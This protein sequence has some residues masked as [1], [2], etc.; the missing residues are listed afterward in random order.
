MSVCNYLAPQEIRGKR[1]AG[2]PTNDLFSLGVIL[3]ECLTGELPW[4]ARHAGELV[5]GAAGGPAPRVSA[6]VLECPVWLDVL[7]ARLLEVK[8][9]GRLPT[10]DATRRAI[11]DAKSKVAAGMG[12]V[13]HALSGQQGRWPPAST[14]RSSSRL[15]KAAMAAAAE[16]H[17]SVLR[18]GVVPGG[19]PGGGDRRRRVGDVAEERG[20]AVR[21][22]E[23]AD[24]FG[25]RDRLAAGAG[26]YLDGVAA[27][28]FPTRRIGDEIEE[29]QFRYA[30][31]RPRSG[32]RTSIASAPTRS[33]RRIDSTTRR[34]GTSSSAIGCRR[35]ANT[36]RWSS[37]SPTART[38]RSD[39]VVGP[40]PRAHDG[41]SHRS[42]PGAGRRA[43]ANGRARKARPGGGARA[44]RS[45]LARRRAWC[46]SGSSKFYDGN[47]EVAPLVD[48]ARQRLSANC[49]TAGERLT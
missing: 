12:A 39:A 30:I 4:Q 46:S 22:G 31:H 48:E 36:R 13:K 7:V 20:R 5:H 26:R 17:Q 27:S 35:G 45:K 37:S 40:G 9:E 6:K 3:Y 44:S 2:L 23:A 32:S 1:S 28:G 21:Q 8:R 41:D 33:P 38:S 14:R 29:F 47:P 42:E 49:T 34:G 24:G 19:V 16:G 18:T 15:R 10:A 11:V 25:A 43:T